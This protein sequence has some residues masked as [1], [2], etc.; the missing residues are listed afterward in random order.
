[1]NVRMLSVLGSIFSSLVRFQHTPEVNRIPF[2]VAF[3][4]SF[5]TPSPS[6]FLFHTV[7]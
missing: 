4:L 7:A 5:F 2:A 6:R 3:S 1:M